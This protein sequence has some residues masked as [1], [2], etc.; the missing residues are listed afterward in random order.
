MIMRR[1]PG[2]T[3]ARGGALV[4]LGAAVLALLACGFFG[5]GDDQ[6][7]LVLEVDSALPQGQL[8]TVEFRITGPGLEAEG[9]T[10]QVPLV[11][12]GAKQFPLRLVLLHGGAAMG[13]LSPRIEGRLSGMM[14]AKVPEA[15]PLY[16]EPGRTVTHHYVL[17]DVGLVPA[18]TTG[19]APTPTSTPPPPTASSAA[20]AGTTSPPATTAPGMPAGGAANPP[21]NQGGSSGSGSQGGSSGSAPQMG[22]GTPA[23]AQPPEKLPPPPP[24]P[25]GDDDKGKGGNNG[26]DGGDGKGGDKGNQGKGGDDKGKGGDKGGDDGK[27]KGGDKGGDDGK[28]KGGGKG[29]DDDD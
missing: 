10:T 6:T 9:R 7:A 8:D 24:P 14:R 3:T 13:P 29:D 26:Q 16:F 25:M 22:G 28:G 4:W 20:D 15:P 1:D 17:Q 19:P 5:C 2:L 18:P 21:S 11:G 27:G 12:V 23:P